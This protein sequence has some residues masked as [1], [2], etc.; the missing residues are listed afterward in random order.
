MEKN[1]TRTQKLI[2]GSLKKGSRAAVSRWD[3]ANK[4][5]MTEVAVRK[6]LAALC[7]YYPVCGGY[8]A[9]GYYI[10]ANKQEIQAYIGSLY[11]HSQG[12]MR[13]IKT[14]RKFI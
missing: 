7:K 8:G 2:L 10:A 13:R 12:I 9:A 14:M 5:G 3:L 1:L 11:E 6:D 4:F